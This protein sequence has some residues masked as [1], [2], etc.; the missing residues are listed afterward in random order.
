MYNRHDTVPPGVRII[1]PIVKFVLGALAG[2]GLWLVWYFDF[3]PGRRHVNTAVLHEH[4]IEFYSTLHLPVMLTLMLV[5]GIL[6]ALLWQTHI[7]EH[8]KH[9]IGE[10]P[11]PD[12]ERPWD[13]RKRNN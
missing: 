11:D 5:C 6:T 13:K 2:F 1:L 7:G 4:T 12:R 8:T 10:G 3:V 9:V